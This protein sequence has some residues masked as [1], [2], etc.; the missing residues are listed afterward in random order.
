MIF[1]PTHDVADVEPDESV[2]GEV[3]VAAHSEAGVPKLPKSE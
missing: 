3:E 1:G 2:L